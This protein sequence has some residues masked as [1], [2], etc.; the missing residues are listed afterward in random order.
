MNPLLGE[1]TKPFRQKVWYE[2][3]VT[4]MGLLVLLGPTV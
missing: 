1:I 4:G 3:S 2:P